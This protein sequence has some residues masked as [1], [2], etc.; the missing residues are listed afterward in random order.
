MYYLDNAATTRPY[1]QLINLV[2]K[3]LEEH[4]ANPS[5]I[6][7][8]GAKAH[9]LINNSRKILASIFNVPMAG[10]IFCCSGTESDNL[11]L[12]GLF[13]TK[14]D[15]NATLVTTKLEH[16]AILNTAD[17]LE[18]QGIQV[19]FIKTNR[20]TGQ[21]DLRHLESIIDSNTRLVSVQHVNSETG[22]VQDLAEIAKVIKRVSPEIIFHSDGVQAFAKIPTS[23]KQLGVD[24]YSISAHKFHGIKGAGALIAARKLPLQALL[25]GGGQE[26]GY[27]S[28]TEN[29][30][31]IAAMGE[32]VNL[33]Y[34]NFSSA[35]QQV[36]AFAVW[37]KC[38]LKEQFRNIRILE[39]PH[40]V[41]HIIC[42]SIPGIPGEV[43]LNHLAA[44]GIYVG[45]GSACS[46]NTNKLSEVLKSLNFSH[47]QIKETI[48]ISLSAMEIP[49]DRQSF[50]DLFLV[51]VQELLSIQ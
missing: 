24:L 40:S 38:M 44:Q 5:S 43:L 2:G 32:A 18:Q 41:P 39:T 37:F 6:H 19:N 33:S 48:R 12:K 31:A 16:A 30:A 14:L 47:Q 34:K 20:T 4:Y 51:T 21:I 27:R 23:L 29:I 22:I 13:N 45:L 15:K 1:P 7:P 49:T 8:P 11:A 3:Y 46:A 36:E 50:L 10:V 25:H 28:G 9:H 26:S 42:L 35:V 17:W